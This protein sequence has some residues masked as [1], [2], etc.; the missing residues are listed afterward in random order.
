MEKIIKVSVTVFFVFIALNTSIL[1]NSNSD[2]G[3]GV[4]FVTAPPT[5][6][7]PVT[8]WQ[9][10]SKPLTAIPSLGGVLNWYSAPIAGVA[11]PT[12]PIPNTATIGSTITYYVSQTIAGI[13]SIR[14][15]IVVNVAVDNGGTILN[16]R[17][18]CSQIPLYSLNYSPPATINN[19]VLFDWSNNNAYLSQTYVC[20]YSIQG[21]PSIIKF[22]PANESHLIVPDLLPGQ[23]VELTLTS[24]SHPCVP[25]QKITCRVPC[26]TSIVTPLFPPIATT[27]CLNEIPA[28]LP[29][30]TNISIITGTW[31]PPAINTTLVGLTNYVFTPDPI[32]YPCVSTK[33][34]TITVKPLIIPTFTS[35]PSAVCQNSTPLV[36]PLSSSN[37]SPI[38]GT[39]SSLTIDTSTVGIF[40]YIFTADPG[41]CA[42]I[43]PITVS[44]SVVNP[45]NSLVSLDW[46]VSDAFVDNQIV[47]VI[48]NAAGTYLYQLDSGPF[49]SSPVFEY[50][51]SGIH[52]ITVKDFYCCNSPLTEN[53]VLVINSPK[54]FTPNGDGFNDTW[55]IFDLKDQI[56]S[57]IYIF[58][59]YGKLLKEISPKGAGWDGNYIG[60]PMPATDYW[61][62][63]D[64]AEQSIA[65]KFKSHFSLKR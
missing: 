61:F 33:I 14:V 47:T 4:S 51:A 64:Y 18:D 40:P 26:G 59:R 20:T 44:V 52:S 21:G 13:E 29:N 50:V 63:V 56:N 45:P 49:Q 58:D 46:T 25:S 27:Y 2:D 5:V 9:N 8:Y 19:S 57:R 15:P 41:Q 22:N 42:S 34:L 24:A 32:L 36:L 17:C 7:S 23:S 54:F 3:R 65:K 39:W 10:C 11:S 55:N 6:Y 60:H 43:V 28:S 48:P 12:A 16:F 1:A 37:A 31:S 30:P 62:T 53:N 38:T 35:I